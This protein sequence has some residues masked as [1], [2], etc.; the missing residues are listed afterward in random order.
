LFLCFHAAV[1]AVNLERRR[2]VYTG[3]KDRFIAEFLGKEWWLIGNTKVEQPQ[4]ELIL[5]Q[6]RRLARRSGEFPAIATGYAPPPEALFL[7]GEILS[8]SRVALGSQRVPWEAE[9]SYTG[10]TSPALLKDAGVVYGIIGHRESRDE[11]GEGPRLNRQVLTAIDAGIIPIVCCGEPKNT[12]IETE[13]Q[14]EQALEKELEPALKGLR[15]EVLQRGHIVFAY[16]P[17]H[18]IGL[19][20]PADIGYIQSGFAL[21]KKALKKLGFPGLASNAWLLYG[22]GVNS[23]TIHEVWSLDRPS[24]IGRAHV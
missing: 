23:E 21:V 5:E 11:F 1:D 3:N 18:V 10:G 13:E 22:G 6:A 9:G 4:K 2:K 7:V 20:K 24:K 16:E 12:T 17:G 15:E 19:D 14:R 8:D